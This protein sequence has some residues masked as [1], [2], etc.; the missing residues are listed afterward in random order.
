MHYRRL[1]RL[2]GI[3]LVVLAGCM[4]TSLFWTLG[5]DAIR[6]TYA[7]LASVGI[8]AGAGLGLWM[9]GRRD[10]GTLFRS[11]AILLVALSWLLLGVFGGLPYLLDGA[12]SNP[13]D[14]YFEAIS[15]FTTTGATV[16]VQIADHSYG[17]HWWRG[18]TH[19]LG[20]MG[21]VVL[22]VAIF[23]QLGVGGKFL[24]KSE[25]PGPVTEGLKPKI[26]Q[27][28]SILW[29]I[30]VTLTLTLTAILWLGGMTLHEALIHAFSTMSTGGFSTRNGSVG[31]YNSAFFDVVIT[32][33]M[34]LGGVNFGLYHEVWRGRWRKVIQDRELWA[35]L[36]IIT[37][38][39][40]LITAQVW[41]ISARHETL[42]S[43]LRYAAFQVVSVI[44]TTGFMTDDFD[45]YPS[46]SK[47]LLILIM[48]IGGMAGSTSGG[49]KVIRFV[50]VMK[51]IHAEIYRVFR[52]QSVVTIRVGNA[53]LPQEVVHSIV[54]F[55][56]LGM[57]AFGG[58]SLYMAYLGLDI[59]SATTSVAACLF[60][61]GPGLARVGPTQSFAFVPD[62][63]KLLLSLCMILGRLE[64]MT[65]LVL[66]LPEFWER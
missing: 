38:V 27:T 41:G 65:L 43:S 30:Y 55:L 49:M 10:D 12:F 56:M 57:L 22:F 1:A 39:T 13:A 2:L 46:M 37:A 26:K 66:C 15:G 21:I 29:R 7:F 11:D 63:G 23:P 17:L 20:G 51:A 16:M 50:V 54:V 45:L 28:A 33:F 3:L 34:L 9:V 44:T 48:F 25:V 8:T 58:A 61:V 5:Y 42:W 4:S 47:L 40:A 53:P 35:Y 36:G 18:L 64:F 6:S 31:E 59:V 32:I 60:N 19:W 14:A 24:F 62:S 52:P